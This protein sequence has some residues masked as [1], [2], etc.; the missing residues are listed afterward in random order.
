MAAER[1]V[2]A[3]KF[4]VVAGEADLNSSFIS[5]SLLR[6][7]AGKDSNGSGTEALEDILNGAAEAIAIGQKQHD[8]RDAPGHASHG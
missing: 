6:G 7:A 3:Q 4:D 2:V 8:G 5:A 1:D